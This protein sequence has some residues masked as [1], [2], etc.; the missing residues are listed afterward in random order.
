[1]GGSLGELEHS[2]M[3]EQYSGKARAANAPHWRCG[4]DLLE[5]KRLAHV[6]LYVAEWTA[7]RLPASI[8]S[9]TPT[10]LQKWKHI[11]CHRIR[12]RSHGHR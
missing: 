11:G 10:A 9:P 7:K 12:R 2:I 8:S 5:N 4:F 6:L 3:L 1:V